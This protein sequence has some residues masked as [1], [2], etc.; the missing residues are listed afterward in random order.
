ME[1]ARE[2]CDTA[3]E[4]ART[5]YETSVRASEARLAL[6]DAPC[7]EA[8]SAS[9]GVDCLHVE[10]RDAPVGQLAWL[11]ERYLSV[12]AGT[13][14]ELVLALSAY[15]Q[16]WWFIVDTPSAIASRHAHRLDLFDRSREGR[17]RARMGRALELDA[18]ACTRFGQLRAQLRR[19]LLELRDLACAG[20]VGPVTRAQ[21]IGAVRDRLRS[22]YGIARVAN[23]ERARCALLQADAMRSHQETMR[24]W[25]ESFYRSIVAHAGSTAS[26]GLLRLCEDAFA[27]LASRMRATDRMA[28]FRARKWPYEYQRARLL[29]GQP[30][31]VLLPLQ[32]ASREC[33]RMVHADA[34]G[35]AAPV[36][37]TSERVSIDGA[38]R[39]L[40]ALVR[41]QE[42]GRTA[43]VQ[44]WAAI[45][46]ATQHD[47]ENECTDDADHVGDPSDARASRFVDVE[48]LGRGR[49]D[50]VSASRH[51]VQP[52]TVTLRCV[53]ELSV[54][55]T[56]WR[57]RE[58]APS[59]NAR[60]LDAPR[61]ALALLTRTEFTVEEL[62]EMQVRSNAQYGARM[63]VRVG[64]EIYEPQA[65]GAEAAPAP[66]DGA[67]FAP[68]RPDPSSELK[69][70]GCRTPS[71]TLPWPTASAN[72]CA[73]ICGTRGRWNE[74]MHASAYRELVAARN[75]G[76]ARAVLDGTT[77]P[78]L[79]LRVRRYDASSLRSGHAAPRR[80]MV[81]TV[82]GLRRPDEQLVRIRVVSAPFVPWRTQPCK[83]ANRAQRAAERA[84]GSVGPPWC[85]LADDEDQTAYRARLCLEARRGLDTRLAP[86]LE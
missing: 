26:C 35:A 69:L 64:C 4:V 60:F 65:D 72:G 78:A 56:R 68:P 33:P 75:R 74:R 53:D 43:R 76:T 62:D 23:A 73:R 37:I 58:T 14:E 6:D 8:E 38:P 9:L 77:V 55:G 80:R 54:L 13:F 7:A 67:S 3:N 85:G 41:S 52:P 25:A 30:T 5:L 2:R 45:D 19:A 18:G 20:C 36:V 1:R 24:Q 12:G 70:V 34:S 46:A 42:D 82:V 51:F 21:R 28:L 71:A 32:P 79:G 84:R 29:A 59:A 86:Q 10:L 83:A 66:A 61:L 49:L 15:E 48:V 31:F 40:L 44:T 50:K 27:C 17:L 47:G 22:A 39:W 57:R 63:V 81:A 11:H 16:G